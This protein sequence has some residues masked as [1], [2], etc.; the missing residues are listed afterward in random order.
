VKLDLQHPAMILAALASVS[1]TLGSFFEGLGFGVAPDLGFHMVLTGVWFGLVVGFGVWRWVRRS[2][3]AA[4][5]AFVATWVGWEL[6]VNLALQLE[7][8]GLKAIAVP[9]ELTIYLSGFAAGAVGALSLWAGAAAFAPALRKISVS[10]G[11]VSAGAL[12]G[13][14]LPFTNNFDNA[15]VLL[16]PWQLTIAALLGCSIGPKSHA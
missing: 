15:L 7:E 13:L 11:L 5:I 10:V 16:L 6:A 4:A 12:L 8:R 3:G 9:P 1:A 2:W 14:L